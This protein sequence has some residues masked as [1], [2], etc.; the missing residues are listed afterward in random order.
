MNSLLVDILLFFSLLACVLSACVVDW[1]L[2][3]CARNAS[4]DDFL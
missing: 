3:V 4:N 2:V 1:Y